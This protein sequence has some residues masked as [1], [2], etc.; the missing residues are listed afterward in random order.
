M[1]SD[2]D[3]LDPQ[4]REVLEIMIEWD[5]F[6]K[7]S[8][9]DEARLSFTQQQ[10]AWL[11]GSCE[12][13]FAGIFLLLKNGLL[14]EA[15]TLH[16]TLFEN[17]VK[18]VYFERHQQRLDEL[19]VRLVY[20]S[21]CQEISLE[22]FALQHGVPRANALELRRRDLWETF[23]KGH[24]LGLSE[25]RR[26]PDVRGL[27][28]GLELEGLYFG[29]KLG[30]HF[31]HSSRL[32]FA[33]RLEERSPDVYRVSVVA[34]TLDLVSDGLTCIETISSAT[35]AFFNL[36]EWESRHEVLAAKIELFKRTM[37]IRSRLG[38]PAWTA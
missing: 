9:P 27:L 32:S 5:G 17:T 20:T 35:L 26:L 23:E 12:G 13:S 3:N 16:R 8:R 37:A 2:E 21:I 38:I 1:T 29:F 6:L 30:S 25:L 36:M 15:R 22:E 28:V 10:V 33:T 4:L 11:F 19:A 24:E 18:L 7:R 31:T 34:S 14:A